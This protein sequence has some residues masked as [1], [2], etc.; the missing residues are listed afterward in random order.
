MEPPMHRIDNTTAV[1][2]IPTP[3]QPG[4]P[5]F[6]TNGDPTLGQPATIV[7]ADL[8]NAVQ[9][10]IAHV[11]EQAGI[12]LSKT[13]R[14]QLYQALGKLTRIRLTQDTTFYISPLGSNNNDGLTPETP[15]SDA[16]Y[17][18]DWIRDR[19]DPNGH[20][21]TLQAAP[22]TYPGAYFEYPIIGGPFFLVGNE[23]DPTQVVFFNNNGHAINID[24]A[25]NVIILGV[26]VRA[27]GQSTACGV[28]VIQGS[29][30]QFNNM[31]F[32]TCVDAHINADVGSMVGGWPDPHN[33]Q[34]TITGSA[35]AHVMAIHAGFG[36]ILGHI[37]ISGTPTFAYGFC[38]VVAAQFDWQGV[39]FNGT[40]HGPRYHLQAG[41][42][43]ST[44]NSGN[45][46]FF[47]GD[48]PGYNDGT[49]IYA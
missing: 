21:I 49:G 3:K 17:G 19:I 28:T 37:T 4:T 12:V 2:T 48:A 11:I 41:G 44:G 46:N 14:T 13:D 10:E 9:E 32:D 23:A 7:E 18:Y 26:T 35:N 20:T 42:I 29:R 22:G 24:S 15:W 40:C 39:T 25:A 5:G 43:L 38:M 1:A 27:S 16:T 34:Y 8:L 47:P 36:Q 6:F 33:I 31:I 30:F 45:P